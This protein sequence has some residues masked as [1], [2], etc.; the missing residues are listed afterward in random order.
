ML[1]KQAM[2][3]K[4]QRRRPLD[5]KTKNMAEGSLKPEQAECLPLEVEEQKNQNI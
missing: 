2:T 4:S 3:Y 5:W 1:I